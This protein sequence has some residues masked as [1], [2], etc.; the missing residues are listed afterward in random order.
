[1]RQILFSQVILPRLISEGMVLQRDAEVP[2]WG[3]AAVGEQ[4][5]V[6]FMDS[7]YCTAADSLGNWHILL[8][9][10]KAG[11][12][13]TMQFRSDHDVTTVRDIM[14]GDVWVC[15][16]QSNMELPMHRVS[17]IYADEIANSGN[18]SIRLFN[19]PYK[20]DFNKPQTDVEA[21]NWRSADPENVLDF[22]AVAYFFARELYETYKV[23][24]GLINASLGGSP[25][26][27]WMSEEALKEF[28]VYFKEAQRFKDGKLIKQIEE[29]DKIR[30]STWYGELRR[31]DEG[32]RDS[33]K[34]WT[35]PVLNTSG[36]KKMKIPGYWTDT[37]LEQMNGV[38]WFRKNIRV[39]SSMTGIPAKLILG[40]VI[41]ADS[42]FINGVF[43]GTTGYQY[44]PRRYDIP[45]DL[46]KKGDNSIVIRVISNIGR[47][48]FVPDKQ[49]AIIAEDRIID[50]KGDWLYQP[51]ARME[52]LTGQ[53]FISWKPLGLFNG[54]IA[55]LLNWRI[56]GVI[57]YQ[58]ESNADRPDEYRT[59]FP[60]LIRDW[61]SHWKQGDLPFLY[62]QLPNFME[63]K[64]EP[65]FGTWTLMREAQSD[66]LSV[67]NTG[68]AVTIDIGEWNDIHPLNK[69][70]VG[71]RLAQAARKV[72]YGDDIVHS[73]PLYSARKTEGNRIILFFSHIGSGLIARGKKLSGFAIAGADSHFVW[74]N[75]KIE[76]NS[77]IVWNYKIREPVFV[78][79]AWADS[80][81]GANLYNKEGLPAAPFRT[82][83]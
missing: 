40:L 68:M 46:L 35:N 5:L 64:K 14:I 56:K 73:G 62:A 58:G 4:V 13:Y 70:D 42:V 44:P 2:V 63:A 34:N 59:L 9:G 19:I 48:G 6:Q 39:P 22:S 17:R 8:S 74:A 16:G 20:Y 54:M 27:A 36:W 7:T 15:S 33:Q 57:W 82:D 25:A 24:I 30:I 61:R 66:A 47:G 26:E 21:G 67:P 29:S 18:T 60:A 65:S 37:E 10:L 81:E 80:P 43:V 28:P 53:T 83:R 77:V 1:M 50:L 79:Y 41:D 45:P 69:K 76:D 72:A 38:V 3:W 31:K 32:Y 51:G 78:R 71:K 49:Y 12:P 55:P 52:P 23:P 75:A 11:G